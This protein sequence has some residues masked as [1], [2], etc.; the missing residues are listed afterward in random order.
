[1]FDADLVFLD[2]TRLEY[3]FF[4]VF[5]QSSVDCLGSFKSFDKKYQFNFALSL[6]PSYE[7]GKFKKEKN[8]ATQKK[9]KIQFV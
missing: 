7:E 2:Y 5:V 4:P 8:G 9:N 6:S 3:L 1:M